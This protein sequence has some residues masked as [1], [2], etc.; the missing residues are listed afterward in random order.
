METSIEIKNLSEALVKAQS[1]MVDVKKTLENPHTKSEYADLA[2]VLKVIRPIL[3]R[4]DLALIQFPAFKNE[5][6]YVVSRLVHKTGEW[7]QEESSAGIIEQGPQKAGSA[8]TYL[9]RYSVM[10]ICGIAPEDDDASQSEFSRKKKKPASAGD[11][12]LTEKS[13]ATIVSA[14][15]PAIKALMKQAKV[16]SIYDQHKLWKSCEGDMDALVQMLE[17]KIRKQ[18]G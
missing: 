9:R 17:E 18:N 3:F 15:S 5:H 16:F 2:S 11:R 7:M 12:T 10:A 14:F 8:I 4:H 6:V 1:E 13:V